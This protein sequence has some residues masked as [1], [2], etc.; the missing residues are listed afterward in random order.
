M[1]SYQNLKD[2]RI[3]GST[4]LLGKNKANPVGYQKMILSNTVHNLGHKCTPG[5]S[6][7]QAPEERLQ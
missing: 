7:F 4:G 1:K 2:H 3:K 5:E 6:Y